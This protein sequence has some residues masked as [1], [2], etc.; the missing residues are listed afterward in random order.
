[1]VKVY[2]SAIELN[3][4]SCFA[5]AVELLVATF[6]V[7]NVEYAFYLKATFE[8]IE[9]VLK[10]RKTPRSSVARELLKVLQS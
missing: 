8:I 4:V 1:L 5:D 2:Q 9:T 3:D 10:L 7:F 6:Y